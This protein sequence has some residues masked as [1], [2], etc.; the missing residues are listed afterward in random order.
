MTFPV[1]TFRVPQRSQSAAIS[2]RPRPPSSVQDARLGIWAAAED[3]ALANQPCF[4]STQVAQF[5]P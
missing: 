3:G 1:V 5:A 2:C 4:W